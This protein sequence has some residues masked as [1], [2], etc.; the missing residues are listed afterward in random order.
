MARGTLLDVAP[1]MMDATERCPAVPAV[2]IGERGFRLAA[3]SDRL[4]GHA[5]DE[6]GVGSAADPTLHLPPADRALGH[7]YTSRFAHA[8]CAL[9]P[10]ALRS[11]SRL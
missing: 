9:V 11:R 6:D 5:A 10:L 4:V 8:H 3:P 1:V 7:A 2:P